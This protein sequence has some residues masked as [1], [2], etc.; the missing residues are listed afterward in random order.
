MPVTVRVM[1]WNIQNFGET[2]SGANFGNYD[3]IRAIAQI[4]R[5]ANIDIFVMLEMNTTRPAVARSL[6]T[7]MRAYLRAVSGGGTA[8]RTV[9]LS[10]NTGRE[11]YAYFVR[12]NT[13]TVPMPLQSMVGGGALPTT[14][15]R[16]FGAL[17]NAI[18]AADQTSG[19]AANYFPLVAPDLPDTV[20]AT[21][22]P[23]WPGVRLPSLGLFRIAGASATNAYFPIVA[24]HYA[25]DSNKWR[26]SRQVKTLRHFSLLQGLAYQ[27]PTYA[28]VQLRVVPPAG[29]APVQY[30]TNYWCALGDFN[31]DIIDDNLRYAPLMGTAAPNLGADAAI[32][33]PDMNTHMVTPRGY[34]RRLNTTDKLA[35]HLYDNFFVRERPGTTAPVV[36]GNEEVI[37]IAELVRT[38]AVQLRASVRHYAELDK[39]GFEEG[40]YREIVSDF[41]AQLAGDPSHIINVR[42]SL[43]G[44]RLISDHLPTI[45]EFDIS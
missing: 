12:D 18:F 22:Y 36:Y 14:L 19:V 42:G 3:V 20:G 34:S 32:T 2:K 5:N 1:N 25:A 17:A 11:F 10:P 37:N 40:G 23:S 43:A 8:W 15:G 30:T 21:T 29:G 41:N 24:C 35:T 16:G 33:D 9:V 6:A 7:D 27:Q 39:R 45:Y 28:P 26:Q 13:K 38:R 31:L 44:A 4:V